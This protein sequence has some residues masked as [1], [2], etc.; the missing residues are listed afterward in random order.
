MCRH[1]IVLLAM[2]V[3]HAFVEEKLQEAEA[4]WK[5]QLQEET[6]RAKKELANMKE[7]IEHLKANY[8]SSEAWKNKR[9]HVEQY[10]EKF[11]LRK[12]EANNEKPTIKLSDQNFAEFKQQMTRWMKASHPLV[13]QVIEDLERPENRT[14]D[15]VEIKEK[16]VEKMREQAQDKYKIQ[17]RDV[18]DMQERDIFEEEWYDTVTTKMWQIIIHNTEATCQTIQFNQA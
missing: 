10:K 8:S 17:I 14:V 15:E 5:Q 4:R 11:A 2:A 13:K 6:K 1:L 9:S 7:D 16:L 12:K 18:M 3:S